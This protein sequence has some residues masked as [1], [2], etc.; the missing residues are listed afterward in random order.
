ML[1]LAFYLQMNNNIIEGMNTQNLSLAVVFIDYSKAFNSIHRERMFQIIHAYG[2][3][4][5]II[6][7]SIKPI[8]TESSALVISANGDTLP[9]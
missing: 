9:F 5:V 6:V 4:G 8:F 7:D 1:K 2:M 3:P